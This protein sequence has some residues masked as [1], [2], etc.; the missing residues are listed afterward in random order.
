MKKQHKTDCIHEGTTDIFVVKQKTS[1]K[2]P[3]GR[4]QGPFYNP[5]MELNRDLS[6]LVYQW[7]VSTCNKP[8]HLVDGLAASGIR[9]VRLAHEIQGAFD[10]TINDWDEQ[11]YLLIKRN[12]Q[13]NKV[14]NAIATQKNLNVLL[15][16]NSYDGIDIDPFGSPVP[17]VD[18]AMRSISHNGL[19]AC[20]ATDTATLCGVYPQVCRRRYAAQPLYSM[21][22][23][24]VGLRILL[25]YLCREAAKYD[26][27]IK[28]LICYGTDHYFRVYI[29]I[30]NG[31]NHAHEALRSFSTI[32]PD[33]ISFV[34]DHTRE[35]V[36][37]LWLGALQQKHIVKELR[38]M[39][40]DKQLQTKHHLWKLLSLC[41]EEST[42]SPLFYTTSS[43]ASI[44][45]VSPPRLK[46][47]FQELEKGGFTATRTH[48]APDG[49]KTNAPEEKLRK[50][51]MKQKRKP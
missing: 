3:G 51:F 43:I 47:I 27:G 10:V 1:Q 33:K 21:M 30:R 12:I 42:G 15:A 29:Q 4:Q 41:E 46:Q 17:F 49:F 26:K 31:K 25:G 14:D 2:G 37:P 32:P 40:F 19:L 39:L 50:I 35:F 45:H 11:A 8:V 44:L 22:M 23:K 18:S 16:E 20:T 48:F 6:I 9:G 28:P 7:F 36:G 5:A 13:H 34:E 38:T 24:E